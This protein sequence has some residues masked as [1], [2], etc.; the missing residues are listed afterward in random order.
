M[1]T[2]VSTKPRSVG[3]VTTQ[4]GT[5]RFPLLAI[6]TTSVGTLLA[7]NF[8]PSEP[9][10]QGALV[11]SALAL[12]IGLAIAPIMAALRDQKSILLGEHLLALA[13]IYWL[14]LDLLQGAY[15]METIQ[16]EQINIAFIG[17]GLFV[18]AVWI[19]ASLRP[20]RFS[21]SIIKTVSVEFSANVYFLLA[22]TAFALGMLRFAIP[23]NFNLIEMIS[24]LG[25]G[26]WAAP[27]QRG[28]LGGWDAFLDHMA[29][30]GYLIPTLTVIVA[31]RTSWIN[32]RTVLSC[33]MSLVMV[34]FIAQSGSRRTVGV[35]F[36]MAFILW[37]LT[38]PR[39]RVRHTLIAAF[40][41][42]VILIT[43]Q[44]MMEY[45]RVGFTDLLER[46]QK[47]KIFEREYLHVDDNFYRFC[48]IIQFI[49]ESYPYVYHKY[50]IWI[51]VRPIPRV[52]WPD[53]PV[54]PG[55]DLPTAVGAEGI[56]Y[57]SSVI[58]EL[59]MSAGLIGI[60]LGGLFYGKLASMANQ[61]L[62]QR[63]TFGA[64]VIY[65]VMM[66]ALFSG[67]RSMLELI[68]VSYVVLAWIGLSHLIINLGGYKAA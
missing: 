58:G 53:K 7:I 63:K 66:M 33:L 24:F 54:D 43:M 62:T 34:T 17:I 14:L 35:I 11:I 41:L 18:I 13:P 45:R 56:S 48:Q 67:M 44:L 49:P 32:I 27:W 65:S 52:F 57:S 8:I 64:V 40:S 20:W 51:L 59:Y 26:R 60:V 21:E 16:P 10:P 42:A 28:Q 5:T 3:I 61:L 23:C 29:Y 38:E 37:V 25:E 55:F 46:E 68:L 1:Q 19:G 6:I 50:F 15:T 31:R 39:L 22:M 30:F 47:E 12:S 36:G 4:T 9:E 2:F